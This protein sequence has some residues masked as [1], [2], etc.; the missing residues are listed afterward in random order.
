VRAR[1]TEDEDIAV[2]AEQGAGF[3]RLSLTGDRRPDRARPRS[4]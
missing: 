2:A 1:R 4:L 3:A